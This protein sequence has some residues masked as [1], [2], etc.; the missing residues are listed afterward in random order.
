MRGVAATR[1][2]EQ[3]RPRIARARPVPSIRYAMEAS[4]AEPK[5]P[6]CGVQG[7]DHIVA[8]D[9]KETTRNDLPLF[10]VAYCEECGHVYGVFA[11]YVVSRE[12]H[13]PIPLTNTFGDR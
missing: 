12:I 1:N 5:C 4:M 8:Q 3:A 11:K 2:V 6:S 10:N 7:I 13:D 9:S